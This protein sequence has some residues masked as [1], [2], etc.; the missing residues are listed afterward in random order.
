MSMVPI[1]GPEIFSLKYQQTD[2][3]PKRDYPKYHLLMNHL[4]HFLI[5]SPRCSILSCTSYHEHS[6]CG[7]ESCVKQRGQDSDV[8]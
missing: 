2:L 4:N 5:R 8:P 3:F 7:S 6:K 1:S